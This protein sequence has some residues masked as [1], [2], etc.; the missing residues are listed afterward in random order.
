MHTPPE[1]KDP[2]AYLTTEG[3]NLKAAWVF[4]DGA[5]DLNA[6]YSNDVAAMLRIYGVEAARATLIKEISAVFAVYGIGV[7][8]RHL[9][10]IAD[11]MVRAQYESFRIIYTNKS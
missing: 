2:K 9:S 6:I 11:Y 4:G 3:V 5:L 10:L 8:K 7:D 1:K